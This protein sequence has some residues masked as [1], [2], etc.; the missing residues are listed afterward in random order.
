[1]I[2]EQAYRILVESIAKRF[3]LHGVDP[4]C[5]CCVPVTSLSLCCFARER[6]R[7]W[8]SGTPAV[9][10]QRFYVEDGVTIKIL[11]HTIQHE[12]TLVGG[13]HPFQLV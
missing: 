1:M 8:K 2:S 11:S 9:V 7:L 6:D 4:I 3:I 10:P 13:K 5:H 12:R